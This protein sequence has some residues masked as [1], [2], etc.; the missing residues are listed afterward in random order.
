MKSAPDFEVGIIGGGPAG[1]SMAA[2]L[3]KNGVN[4]VV[5]ERELMPRPHVGE[6]LVPS[7]TRVFKDLNFLPK[8]EE[9]KFPHKL[10]A[11]WT[12]ASDAKVYN[13]D[14]GGMSAD[15][16]VNVR[17]EERAQP[18]VD[19]NYTYHVDRS[20]FD[21]M[22][23]QHAHEYGAKV[24]EGVNVS[25][26]DFSD[27]D[28]AAIK[29]NMG[30]KEMSTTCRIV[31]DATGRKTLVGN[32]LK[33]RIQDDHFDQYAIH[34]WFDGYD[35]RCMASDKKTQ[36][37]FIFIHFLPITN[38]WVWQIPI[39]DTVTSIGVVTQKKNF[40]KSK[41]SR[42]AF[43][44]ECIKSR[45]ELFEGLTAQGST[46]MHP[47]KEEGDYSYAMKQLCGDRLLLVGDAGRFVD[48]IF[49]TGVSIALNSSRFAHKDILKSLET[50]DFSREAF[51][52]YEATLKRGTRNW[53]NFISVYYRL[54][55]LFTAFVSD[56]RYRL[57]VLKLLQG[58]VYE[59]AE[60]PVLTRMR[61]I[62]EAVERDKNHALHGFL[63]DI[64][65]DAFVEASA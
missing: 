35:R 52:E 44:W 60:P 30:K 43:F 65:A 20:K 1:G 36:G 54:N 53:Y 26:V 56:P 45:P 9:A 2:Y 3:A 11:A 24:C 62:V 16:N 41:E 39:T 58:D 55:V 8:M 59:E 42:E 64:T 34:A 12:A 40:A 57:D 17:F 4:C 38:T 50:G 37:D 63:G 46:Q 23:L 5:F 32:Q 29:F 22:L 33:W 14:F 21:L 27:P 25:R 48:P 28:S 49:S 19:Q 18:G 10:G 6:S 13:M 47:L 15:C 51:G 7:S 31:V 61:S